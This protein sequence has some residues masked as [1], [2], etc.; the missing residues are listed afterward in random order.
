V[1]GIRKGARWLVR[2][3]TATALLLTGVA[4]TT[5][6]VS[7]A[8]AATVKVNATVSSSVAALAAP[9]VG[10][11]ATPSGH[12]YWRVA[13]DGG[14]LTAGD[15]HYYGSAAGK[16]HDTVVAM[17]AT[18]NGG[19]YWIADRRGI[20]YAFGNARFKG[21][22]RAKPLNKPIVG[23]AG[24]PNGQGYWMVASDG[25]IFTF[26]NAPYRGSMGG[27][28]LNKPV[29]GMA[30]TSN[31][32]GYWLVASD[33]GMFTFNAPFKGS[34]GGHRL[35]KPIIGMAP[36]PGGQGYALVGSDGG[37]FRFGSNVPFYGSAANACPGASAVGVAISPGAV[38]YWITFANAVT[39]PFS[40]ATHSPVCGPE[41]NSK[42]AQIQR[43]FLK[44]LNQERAGR[45]LPGVVWDASLASYA[46]KW[47]QDMAVHGFRHSGIGA[48]LG[49]YNFVGENIAK[50][51]INMKVG[52]LHR[53][54]MESTSGHR[55][56]ILAPGFTRVGIGVVCAAGDAVYITETFGRLTSQGGYSTKA[57]PQ[58][59][60]M[61]PDDGTLTC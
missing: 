28:R 32:Q 44:R 24:T 21:D 36:A 16:W 51:S 47:S 52:A 41:G 2:L 60:I 48:L 29:V 19:G 43:D 31:G 55:D 38:G 3:S 25:G 4:A 37:L 53:A 61:R 18:P 6:S 30:S 1:D 35:N 27:H 12:G 8:G 15:A 17:A 5:P 50:G 14:I 40:P 9:V 42:A 46:T 20:V 7:P 39:Y 22:L 58:N 45:G 10:V 54:W 33:G 49:P 34:M 57:W 11:A 23:I 56:N 59:P 13:K 26:G